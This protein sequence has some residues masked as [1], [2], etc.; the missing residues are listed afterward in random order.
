[1]KYVIGDEPKEDADARFLDL[2]IDI[3]ESYRKR[4]F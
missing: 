3:G 1:M 4:R 2:C